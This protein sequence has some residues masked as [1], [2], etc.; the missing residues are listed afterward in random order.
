MKTNAQMGIGKETDAFPLF[1][2]VYEK[3]TSIILNYVFNKTL[4]SSNFT[5][6]GCYSFC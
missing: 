4:F 6:I 3:E 1:W 5:L 2:N